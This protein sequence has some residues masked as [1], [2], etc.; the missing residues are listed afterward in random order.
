MSARRPAGLSVRR[1][2][3]GGAGERP[4]WEAYPDWAPQVRVTSKFSKSPPP[5]PRPKVVQEREASQGPGSSPGG[6]AVRPP[7]CPAPHAAT[8]RRPPPSSAALGRRGPQLRVGLPLLPASGAQGPGCA[9]PAATSRLSRLREALP[10]GGGLTGKPSSAGCFPAG[11][12]A[13]Q[14]SAC[15]L[16]WMERRAPSWSQR[17]GPEAMAPAPALRPPQPGPASARCF[18]VTSSG[19]PKAPPSHWG[20]ESR[21]PVCTEPSLR[22]ERSTRIFSSQAVPTRVAEMQPCHPGLPSHKGRC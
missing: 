13:R 9:R 12:P 21:A 5:A 17:E 11:T 18:V 19:W 10:A 7:V 4:T 2:Q 1:G 22:P 14:L 3:W 16:L 6:R 15:P 8:A 20:P